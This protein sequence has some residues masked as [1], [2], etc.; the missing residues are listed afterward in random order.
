MVQITA[1]LVLKAYAVGVFPMSEGREDDRMFWVDPDRRGVLPLDDFHLPKRLRR[2]VRSER[3]AVKVDRRFQSVIEQCAA[4]SSGR[5]STW[6]NH[7]I[8]DLF[9]ELYDL[10]YAHS[11]EVYREGE[12]VGGLYGLALG[13][14]FFGESMFSRARDASKVALVHLVGRLIRGNFLLLDCQ[15][16]TDH[17]RQFGAVEI[18]RDEYRRRLSEA[19]NQPSD[20]FAGGRDLSASDVLQ[21]I[22]QT[23]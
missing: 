6:I 8:Q 9:L 17:L 11:V 2:T 4:P 16:I 23:S 10:G 22:T 13:G 3:Y 21:S 1:D 12:L 18:D 19:L 7:D 14:A 20:F 15:F 5:Y